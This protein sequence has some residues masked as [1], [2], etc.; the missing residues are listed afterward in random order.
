MTMMLCELKLGTVVGIFPIV[1]S[2]QSSWTLG[3]R[4][5]PSLFL[6]KTHVVLVL[7]NPLVNAGDLRDGDSIPWLGRSPEVGNGYLLWY[8][9]LENPMERGAW[10]ATVHGVTKSW[11]RLKRLSMHIFLTAFCV[12]LER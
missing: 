3:Q 6:K 12:I 5:E 7:K 2:Y 9:Y 10:W 4:T 11:T 8:S 1:F